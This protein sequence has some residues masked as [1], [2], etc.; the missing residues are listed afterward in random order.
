MKSYSEWILYYHI[1]SKFGYLC[2]SAQQHFF[3]YKIIVPI[4]E[5]LDG[6]KRFGC[7]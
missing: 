4:T 6:T 5:I 3:F 7:G 1:Y 2:K